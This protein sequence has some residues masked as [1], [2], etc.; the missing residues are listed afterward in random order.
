MMVTMAWRAK[1]HKSS[2]RHR[3]R[4]QAHSCKHTHRRYL[5]GLVGGLT[6][7]SA[8]QVRSAHE[9]AYVYVRA[10]VSEHAFYAWS[11]QG[12]SALRHTSSASPVLTYI[13]IL[14]QCKPW[15]LPRQHVAS[16][17]A[18][19][20]SASAVDDG[21]T[22]SAHGSAWGGS[23]RG[24]VP[25]AESAFIWIEEQEEEEEEMSSELLSSELL[26]ADAHGLRAPLPATREH[27]GARAALHT[28]LAHL[29]HGS[30]PV[31][32]SP[33]ASPPRLYS[34]GQD[35]PT[36][37]AAA[38]LAAAAPVALPEM[39]H[40][41]G[42][43]DGKYPHPQDS[44][45]APW[46]TSRRSSA[47][48]GSEHR[49]STDRA[50]MEAVA[51][52]WEVPSVLQPQP[53]QQQQQQLTLQHLQWCVHSLEQLVEAIRAPSVAASCSLDQA[54]SVIWACGSLCTH[55]SR[56]EQQLARWQA[57]G[58]LPEAQTGAS[59]KGAALQPRGQAE[60][61]PADPV[62]PPSTHACAQGLARARRSL[63]A[64]AWV[65]VCQG[66][67]PWHWAQHKPGKHGGGRGSSGH[68]GSAAKTGATP[69]A[70]STLLWGLCQMRLQPD[71]R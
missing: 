54:A 47:S 65:L 55:A 23:S 20:S 59:Q 13:L 12:P 21:S 39:Q 8:S 11:S 4:H 70:L 71:A 15:A 10:S 2:V 1:A 34:S 68:G 58:G 24:A 33:M 28:P 41:G 5:D 36:Q 26:P 45:F 48:A 42:V 9:H 50:A 38:P 17:A 32:V 43:E 69:R 27:D 57:Q 44:S 46:P 66:P 56:A 14:L 30:M 22:L 18:A 61:D 7:C 16:S 49:N 63:R 67:Q 3:D 31:A 29:Q 35:A 6:I 25:T 52:A 19:P 53:L 51:L 40:H 37:H 64:A 62:R 60:S